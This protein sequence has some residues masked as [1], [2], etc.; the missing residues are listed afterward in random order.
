MQPQLAAVHALQL[1]PRRPA[2]E[3]NALTSAEELHLAVREWIADISAE[4]RQAAV[5]ASAGLSIMTL[6]VSKGSK[7]APVMLLKGACNTA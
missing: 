3:L 5:G 1:I 2:E 6:L 7:A 4:N